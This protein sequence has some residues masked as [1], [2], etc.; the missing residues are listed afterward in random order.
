MYLYAILQYGDFKYSLYNGG[1]ISVRIILL[2]VNTGVL[3]GGK[4]T[5]T[6][7]ADAICDTSD[8]CHCRAGYRG[9]GFMCNSEYQSTSLAVLCLILAQDAVK[10]IYC[11]QMVRLRKMYSNKKKK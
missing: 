9:D 2:K 4:C 6:C 3:T 10:E 7:H 8:N 11:A 1:S 5:D